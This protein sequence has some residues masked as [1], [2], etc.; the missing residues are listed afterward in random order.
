MNSI[1]RTGVLGKS[2]VH[3][4]LPR[5]KPGKKYL[6]KI[7]LAQKGAELLIQKHHSSAKFEN[8]KENDLDV[9]FERRPM[10]Y[11]Q[12]AAEYYA[13]ERIAKVRLAAKHAKYANFLRKICR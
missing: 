11:L 5:T 12:V 13:I 10:E 7:R 4:K 1:D 8:K 6:C 9:R 3:L 2:S